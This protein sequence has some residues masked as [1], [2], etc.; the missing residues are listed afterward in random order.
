MRRLSLVLFAL[1]PAFAAANDCKFTARHDFDAMRHWTW[2]DVT[3]R[4]H[5][6][7]N[8]QNK[9]KEIGL[10][11]EHPFFG[12]ALTY[13]DS[14]LRLEIAE[15]LRRGMG[16]LPEAKAEAKS[17]ADTLHVPE[18][19]NAADIS[20]LDACVEIAVSAPEL[21]GIA[22]K[23]ET[24][25]RDEAKIR[26]VIADLRRYLSDADTGDFQAP[27][28]QLHAPTGEIA[29]WRKP[30]IMRKAFG[31]DRAGEADFTGKSIQ[32]P[33]PR[34]LP[35]NEPHRLADRPVS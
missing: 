16:L 6:V 21:D 29:H 11:A 3:R 17:L 27:R 31:E 10:P 33:L 7:R 9:V 13:V 30:D 15:A 24:W 34:G 18:P 12:C 14:T 26:A 5:T 32:R 20:I 1:V 8:L 4:L 25:L 35:V 23:G 19:A 2:S 22:V 28:R